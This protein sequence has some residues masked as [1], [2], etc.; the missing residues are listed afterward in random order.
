M[1]D[2]ISFIDLHI[3]PRCLDLAST[4]K[5]FMQHTNNTSWRPW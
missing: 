4:L 1:P 2:M 5:K 3:F